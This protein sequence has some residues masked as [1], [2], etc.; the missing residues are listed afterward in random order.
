MGIGILFL[1]QEIGPKTIGIYSFLIMAAICVPLS[2]LNHKT[3]SSLIISGGNGEGS[4]LTIKSMV[5]EKASLSYSFLLFISSF[6][7]CIINFI[8]LIATISN[9]VDLEYTEVTRV[10]SSIIISIIVY[11]LSSQGHDQIVSITKYISVPLSIVLIF[12]SLMLIPEWKWQGLPDNSD[13]NFKD[14]LAFIPIIVFAMNFS[15]CV[16]KYVETSMVDCAN[17]KVICNRNISTTL[18][19]SCTA[20]AITVMFFSFSVSMALNE[21]VLDDVGKN[22]NSISLVA[23]LMG[24]GVFHIIG[25]LIVA[26]AS[27][28]ALMGTIIGVTDGL[29]HFSFCK[30]VADKKIMLLV[31]SALAFIGILN[32]NIIDLIK[33][34]SGP[35][36]IVVGMLFPAIVMLKK[37]NYKLIYFIAIFISLVTLLSSY[38]L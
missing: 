23:R 33:L 14:I 17:N 21:S 9:S 16:S 31:C 19:V 3:L 29:K 1:P 4:V 11:M 20:I 5:G 37:R 8:A 28:G 18:I 12:L 25:L 35:S 7:I 38:A 6:S 13:V 10:M 32:P 22:T 2:Y 24:G 15:P 34:I 36:V 26:T 30:K 27:F